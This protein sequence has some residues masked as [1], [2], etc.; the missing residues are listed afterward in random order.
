VSRLRAELGPLFTAVYATAL[1]QVAMAEQELRA[2]ARSALH[3]VNFADRQLDALRK[4]SENLY[5]SYADRSDPND[6]EGE[7]LPNPLEELWSEIENEALGLG[8]LEEL[9]GHVG[10]AMKAL[11]AL[12]RELAK[13]QRT[14]HAIIADVRD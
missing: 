4:R 14:F 9:R 8:D 12:G 10:D 11:K 6:P 3:R 2:A 7:Y 5:Y 1:E 13:Q